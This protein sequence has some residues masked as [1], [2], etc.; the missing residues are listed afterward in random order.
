MPQHFQFFSVSSST[1]LSLLVKLGLISGILAIFFWFVLMELLE[2]ESTLVLRNI[3][4]KRLIYLLLGLNIGFIVLVGSFSWSHGHYNILFLDSRYQDIL[5]LTFLL[6]VLELG[7]FFSQR[8]K[9]FKSLNISQ[10]NG[11]LFIDFYI[12]PLILIF[13]TGVLYLFN[14]IGNS[15][16]SW[17]LIS[18][19]A[20]I[21]FSYLLFKI[22]LL[23]LTTEQPI[24]L[25][26]LSHSGTALYTKKFSPSVSFSDQLLGAY[27]NAVDILGSN[28]ILESG[29]V[30]SIKFQ[31]KFN[32]LIKSVSFQDFSVKFCYIYKGVS[33]YSDQRLNRFVSLVQKDPY[34]WTT[35]QDTI[36]TKYVL[37]DFLELDALVSKCFSLNSVSIMSSL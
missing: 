31:E 7:L 26:I 16:Y 6:F 36:I 23:F 25:M 20:L 4:F 22:P 13:I 8:I 37:K 33:F 34:I 12:I 1:F 10:S 17:L 35:L 30:Y 27:L 14:I 19:P 32:L 2:F 15:N 21:I 3:F 29:S 11:P 28:V 18:L 9:Q 5:V 24:T